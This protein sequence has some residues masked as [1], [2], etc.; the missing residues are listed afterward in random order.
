[1]ATTILTYLAGSNESP[2]G[3]PGMA[4]ALEHMMFRGS[5]GLSADQLSEIA[6]SL[7][8]AFN[9]D[10]SPH[11]TRYHF[12]VPA[13][14]LEVALRIEACRMSGTDWDDALWDKE[15][16]AIDQEVA[17]NL[18]IPEYVLYT[19]MLE[20]LFKGTPYEHTALGTR[21]SFRKTTAAMLQDFHRTWYVPGNAI[22]V[23]VGDVE[24][25]KTM[26]KVREIFGGIPGGRVTAQQKIKLGPMKA[27]KIEM[28]TDKAQGMVI[29]AFR[30]PGSGDPDFA[31]ALV[32][33][34]VLNSRRS[35][36]FAL[37]PAGKALETQF[38]L[39]AFREAGFG[40]AI[41]AFAPGTD[42][43]ALSSEVRKI[44]ISIQK[45]GV[46]ADMVE[47][48]KLRR[49]TDAELEKTSVAGLASVWT[50]ALAI[51]GKQSPD[52][53]MEDIRRVT[54]EDV[55]RIARTYI[56][57]DACVTAVLTPD[58]SDTPVS[59]SDAAGG[60][61]FMPEEVRKV[62]LP[63]WAGDLLNR[64]PVLQSTLKPLVKILP[65]GISLIM[66]NARASNTVSVY[67]RI[68]TRHELSVPDGKEG[69]DILLKNLFPFGTTSL[70]RI[71][72]LKALDDIGAY[73]SS[74]EEFS[75]QVL[76]SH[77]ERGVELLADNQ[78][79]PALPED[80]F[81]VLRTQ[82]AAEAAGRLR[83]PEYKAD[84]AVLAALFPEGDPRLRQAT[85]ASISSLAVTDLKDYYTKTYRPDLTTIVVIGNISTERAAA[86]IEK[87]FGG[88]KAPQTPLP[89]TN[90]PPV[91]DNGPSSTVIANASRVQDKV[92]LAMTLGLNRSHPD[93]YT[94]RLGNQI[95]GGSFF[96]SRLFRDLRKETGLVYG[97]SSEF[98]VN[99]TRAV[100]TVEYAC[101]PQN[102]SR[103]R[104]L[105]EHNLRAMQETDVSP[106]E[107]GRA[108]SQLLRSIPLSESSMEGIARGFIRRTML[109]LPLD[110]PVRAAARYREITAEQVREAFAKW[111]RVHDL[112]QVTQGPEPR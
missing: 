66:Q 33:A 56:V 109:D 32:L 85:P 79:H 110:E 15:R 65:N 13:Q 98:E 49:I 53:A 106:E 102:V 80:A 63:A 3:F 18:S 72:Y 14:D 103:A 5:P 97:V 67:G 108:K 94:L 87:Y 96:S 89:E 55:N 34:D 26:E 17:R 100:Y 64:P 37:V 19:R 68:R 60:E 35:A 4:H 42:A 54:V 44:L 36:L 90:L 82:T 10:T 43:E 11:V 2:E 9:A 75:L 25:D 95:L 50:R 71:A 52:D 47:A 27:Q 48:A 81:A 74:G 24:P 62:G 83:S 105:V 107:L 76:S 21:E 31:A 8:G 45:Q 22:M 28:K 38:E 99:Q 58:P 73:A 29:S 86:A 20:A 6:A 51:E 46:P 23:I 111:L 39:D 41:A 84:R 112:I 57:P 92:T 91:P 40:S 16:G 104:A 88:W 30:F 69:L 7:G 1:M 78:L 93:Y 101:D 12:T 59:G 70:D 61:S 77:F